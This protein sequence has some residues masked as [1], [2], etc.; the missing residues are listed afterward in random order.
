MQIQNNKAYDKQFMSK[1][2]LSIAMKNKIIK[3]APKE[4]N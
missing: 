4:Y 1:T 3:Q 2:K